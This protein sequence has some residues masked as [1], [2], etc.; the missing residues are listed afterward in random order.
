MFLKMEMEYLTKNI[1]FWD[2][3]FWDLFF[4]F[5]PNLCACVR[6]RVRVRVHVRV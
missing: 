5:G 2:T 3:K 1:P 6:V 4:L